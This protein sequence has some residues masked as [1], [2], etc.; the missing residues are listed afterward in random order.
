MPRPP[1]LNALRVFEAAARHGSFLRA[2]AEL[3]VTPAAVSHQIKMLEQQLGVRLF[4]RFNRSVRLTEE[5]Q[6]CLPELRDAFR[7]L[8]NL[9]ERIRAPHGVSINVSITPSFAPKW[10]L[11]RLDR[12][13]TQH[14]QIDVRVSA[15]RRFVDFAREDVHIGLRYG[16]GNYPDLQT[17]LLLDCRVFPVCSPLLTAGRHPLRVPDDLRHHALLHE[18]GPVIDESCPDWARWL[19]EAGVTGIDASRGPCFSDIAHCHDAALAG[20]GVALGKS[21]LA[22][23]D[24]A[25]GRLVKPFALSFTVKYAFY[26]VYP[27]VLR[28]NP[29]IRAFR[30]WLHEEA[31]KTRAVLRKFISR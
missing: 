15:E 4:R 21:I 17:E 18:R 11:P 23:D 31:R 5:G 27:T 20:Q 7:K 12:F 22:A 29:N 13:L 2:A 9:V 24:L 16:L 14:P 26:L 19:R 25:A 28:Q 6:A 1:P 3:H 8:E 10:L 30:L